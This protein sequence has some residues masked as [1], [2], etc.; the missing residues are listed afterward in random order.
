VNIV[1]PIHILNGQPV[2][3][4]CT[5][6]ACRYFDPSAFAPVTTA[7]LGNAGRNI[8]RGPGYFNLD[9]SVM[10]DFKITE[11]FTFQFEADALGLT[12]TLHFNNPTNND[13]NAD[14][15]RADF[16]VV[17][18]TLVTTNASLGGSGG[19]RQWWFGGKVIF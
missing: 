1:G 7:A 19:Q 8:L 17:T 2:E 4:T 15:S 3:G 5:S 16:G 18:S 13:S 9:A 6:N 14:I 12:N 11:R 10:R